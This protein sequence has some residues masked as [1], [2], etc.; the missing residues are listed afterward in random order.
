MMRWFLGNVHS[1]CC[2]KGQRLVVMKEETLVLLFSSKGAGGEEED[3][4]DEDEDDADVLPPP[5]APG[6]TASLERRNKGN[7]VYP[8]HV[9]SVFSGED[10]VC[11]LQKLQHAYR[12]NIHPDKMTRI[13]VHGHIL[14]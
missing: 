14:T 1:P 9:T 6:I 10:N 11:L 5:V 7:L 12:Y 13:H 2:N 8:T 3:P 4:A